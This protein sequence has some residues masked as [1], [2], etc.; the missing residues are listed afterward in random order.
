MLISL[1][2]CQTMDLLVESAARDDLHTLNEIT[3]II[4]SFLFDLMRL[5]DQ[6]WLQS[7]IYCIRGLATQ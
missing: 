2:P 6:W 5:N 7:V 4:F 3:Q 1:E